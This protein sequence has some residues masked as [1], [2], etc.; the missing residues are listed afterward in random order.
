VEYYRL[1]ASRLTDNGVMA[2]WVPPFSDYQY[3]MILRTFLT[4]FPHATLWQSGDLIIGSNAPITIDRA[5]LQARFAD[6]KLT[7]VLRDSGITSPNDFLSRFNATGDEVRARIGPG[8]IITDDRPSIEYFRS[9][10]QDG[11]PDVTRYSR[12]IQAILR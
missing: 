3:K 2:Q 11:P 9:L 6:P 7:A 4:A 10:P 8:P 12:N 1:V 5:R